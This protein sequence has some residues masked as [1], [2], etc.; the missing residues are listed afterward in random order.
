MEDDPNLTS[1]I[2]SANVNKIAEKVKS[3]PYFLST[4]VDRKY[5]GTLL[6]L[7]AKYDTKN[8]TNITR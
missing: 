1:L 2:K 8:R 7:S 3:N 5:N 4:V 6:H